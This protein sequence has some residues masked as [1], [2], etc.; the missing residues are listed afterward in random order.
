MTLSERCPFEMVHLSEW[1]PFKLVTRH[2]WFKV[3][4]L[5]FKC[6]NQFGPWYITSMLAT[7]VTPHGLSGHNGCLP[8]SSWSSMWC[9]RNCVNEASGSRI[10]LR[11]WLQLKK[12]VMVSFSVRTRF[13]GAFGVDIA[14]ATYMANDETLCLVFHTSY[15]GIM[16]G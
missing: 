15:I 6:H 16:W 8:W 13:L 9:S 2:L 14:R 4:C 5:V 3:L 10:Y 7:Y 12:L 11:F 1:W